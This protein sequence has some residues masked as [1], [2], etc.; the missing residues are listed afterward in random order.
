MKQ[1]VSDTCS[2]STMEVATL[3]A[4]FL[5]KIELPAKWE[6]EHPVT[7]QEIIG[8]PTG[9]PFPEEPNYRQPPGLR[10][11]WEIVCGEAVSRARAL[12]DAADGKVRPE[13]LA[14]EQEGVEA[15]G[16]MAGYQAKADE[17]EE[18][19]DKIARGR[20]SLPILEVLKISLPR[21]DDRTLMEYLRLYLYECKQ[22]YNIEHKVPGE[23]VIADQSTRMVNRHE[24]PR[25]ILQFTA[26]LA[27]RKEAWRKQLLRK[28]GKTT[29]RIKR[30]EAL[31]LGHGPITGRAAS[32][33]DKAA[34]KQS[35]EGKRKK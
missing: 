18:K 26:A 8:K 13:V 6:I 4:S 34:R 27:K 14:W 23:I 19:F 32:K 24:F 35:S 2:P 15:R 22:D 16:Q 1:K 30:K 11:A 33:I 21:S 29:Q 10:T 5:P 12:L 17:L 20:D 7:L 3:A 25:F 31:T 9:N 28:G